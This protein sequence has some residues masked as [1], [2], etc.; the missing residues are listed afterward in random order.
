[1]MHHY[2]PVLH[3]GVGD[4][5]GFAHGFSH[6][7]G[8]LDHVLTMLA[9]GLFAA[10]LGGRA[11]WLVPLSFVTVMALGG[12]FGAGAKLPLAEI[13]IGLSVIALGLAIALELGVPTVAAMGFVA[14]VA[15]LH[16]HAHGTEMPETVS[17]L[18]YGAGFISATALLHATGIGLGTTIG[19]VG[20]SRRVVQAGGGTIALAG[21]AILGGIL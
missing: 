11:L 15:L 21:A 1:M 8:G 12:A 18:A 9:V 17:G 16:G 3:T 10:Q 5:T 20:A 13:G 4:A 2:R 6:P 14:F 19:R 7:F